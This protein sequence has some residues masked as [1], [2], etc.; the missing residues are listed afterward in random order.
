M[1]ESLLV[2]LTSFAISNI[3]LDLA[4][5]I[6]VRARPAVGEAARENRS[7]A[8]N[9]GTSRFLFVGFS[10][11]HLTSERSPPPHTCSYHVFY[12]VSTFLDPLAFDCSHIRLHLLLGQN[13][14]P[15]VLLLGGASD[16]GYMVATVRHVEWP[17]SKPNSQYKFHE[18]LVDMQNEVARV[19]R[20]G[21]ASVVTTL[22]DNRYRILYVLGRIPGSEK[23]LVSCIMLHVSEKQ[24]RLPEFYHIGSF[25]VH[26]SNQ[27]RTLW[28]EDPYTNIFY[29]AE[30]DATTAKTVIYSVPFHRL[31]SVL[32][33]GYGGTSER[34]MFYYAEWDATTAKTVKYSVPFH[35]LMSV[36]LYGYGGTSERAMVGR[37]VSLGVSRGIAISFSNET[38]RVRQFI[39]RLADSSEVIICENRS[40]QSRLDPAARLLLLFDKDYCRLIDDVDEANRCCMDECVVNGTVASE[41]KL[42]LQ[43]TPLNTYEKVLRTGLFMLY[44]DRLA[45]S[46]EVIICENRS[47][48]SRLDPAARLL[49]LFD[50]DYCR[51]IDDVDEANRCCMDECVVNGTV[52]S[53]Q[54]REIRKD[55]LL[56][57]PLAF[58]V[59]VLMSVSFMWIRCR[60]GEP[61]THLVPVKD[62]FPQT[63]ISESS[64]EY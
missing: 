24:S 14:P 32:L 55:I 46:S 33:Y 43:Q 57:F 39:H 2:A 12:Q 3:F 10:N 59:L 5:S 44:R 29:Y 11:C 17:L 15:K 54:K 41:Q 1:Q 61:I 51:L 38:G 7:Y 9:F 36:L 35:R 4:I 20:I 13:H 37:R 8:S 58:F 47:P 23:N 34:A 62:I 25:L 45:D 22:L 31:M 60:K 52:A 18:S 42:E 28:T 56:Y 21:Y 40:P 63:F 6:P 26:P 16:F 49:L 53:E 30:W 50:K 64:Y 48:Q 27:K 19:S